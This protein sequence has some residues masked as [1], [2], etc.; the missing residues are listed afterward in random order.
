MIWVVRAGKK[1]LMP[2]EFCMNAEY[3]CLGKATKSH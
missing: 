1:L 3:S 2:I